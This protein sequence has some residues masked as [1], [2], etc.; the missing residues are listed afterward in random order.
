MSMPMTPHAATQPKIR[1]S[2]RLLNPSS[3]TARARVAR[4]CALGKSEA[5]QS[6]EDSPRGRL[7][8]RKSYAK[9]LKEVDWV[10]VAESQAEVRTS[11]S[12]SFKEG[13]STL[14]KQDNVVKNRG[15]EERRGLGS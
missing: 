8:F 4:S 11:E 9:S 5:S 7:R 15:R 3:A 12:C 13:P 1:A 10:V 2:V 6:V 14:S